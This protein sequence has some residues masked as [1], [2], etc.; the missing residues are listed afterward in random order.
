ML[1]QEFV[2]WATTLLDGT[3]P[4]GSRWEQR[5]PR[6]DCRRARSIISNIAERERPETSLSDVLRDTE[7]VQRTIEE[8]MQTRNGTQLSPLTMRN[9]LTSFMAIFLPPT[10]AADEQQ[11]ELLANVGITPEERQHLR[12]AYENGPLKR[13]RR[14]SRSNVSV[15]LRQSRDEVA[16][17]SGDQ[18]ELAE[19]PAEDADDVCVLRALLAAKDAEISRLML[20]LQWMTAQRP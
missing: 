16:M 19:G 4:P 8:H 3:P 5:T 15:P 12:M 18:E 6:E 7:L 20:L 11:G 13:F 14:L 10:P 1:L 17:S 2:E 9:M